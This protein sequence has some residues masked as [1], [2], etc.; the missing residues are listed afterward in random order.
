VVFIGYLL[1][2][3]LL[4]LIHSSSWPGW[5]ANVLHHVTGIFCWYLM[6]E[7]GFGHSI[8]MCATLTEITT[9]FVNQRFFFDKANMKDGSLYV[10]NGL[11]M[12]LLWF[13][14]RVVLFGWLGFRLF[15][16][17]ES[18]FALPNL[19]MF[20]AIFSYAVGYTL[21][22]FWFQKI[23]KGALKVLAGGNKSKEN[24]KN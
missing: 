9:P 21:Q 8:A 14:F 3:L 18:L 5:Q 7:G 20:A 13:L 10:A 17:R 23:M 11:L 22:L 15:Q 19:H 2:D 24:K 4:S 1:S 6:N 16:M 12:T